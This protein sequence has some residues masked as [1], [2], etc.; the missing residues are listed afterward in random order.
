MHGT[1]NLKFL[2]WVLKKYREYEPV[3]PTVPMTRLTDK[4]AV[5]Y[6]KICVLNSLHGGKK[7]FLEYVIVK[8]SR[9]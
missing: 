7:S 9:I 6:F 4:P 1:E 3:M 5:T 8:S 2:V